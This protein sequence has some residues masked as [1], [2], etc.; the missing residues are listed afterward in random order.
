LWRILANSWWRRAIQE[1]GWP[2]EV[3]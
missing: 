1:Q 3:L 2:K